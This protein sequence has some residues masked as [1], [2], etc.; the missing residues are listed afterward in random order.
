M[1]RFRTKVDFV[2][3]MFTILAVF[4]LDAAAMGLAVPA[5]AE[6]SPFAPFVLFFIAALLPVA[7]ILLTFPMGYEI[8]HERLRVRSG[9]LTWNVQLTDI[10]RVTPER[11]AHLAPTMS[12]DRLNV[13][14]QYG[15]ELTAL[16]ISPTE[17]HAFLAELASRD[18]GFSFDGGAITRKSGPVVLLDSIAH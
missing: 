1:K 16:H 2:P 18:R 15:D 7:L 6:V 8:L 3:L 13:V 17:P 10:H 14:Y 9:I 11:S 5:F 12:T 4:L